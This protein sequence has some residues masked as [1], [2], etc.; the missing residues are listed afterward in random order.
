MSQTSDERFKELAMKL[1]SFEC[2]CEEKA[3]LRRII[4]QE[5]ARREELQTRCLSVGIAREL[6]PLAN[7]LEAT[8]GQISVRELEAFKDALARRRK[9]LRNRSPET[10]AAPQVEAKPHVLSAKELEILVLKVL[11]ERP[12]DGFELAG[13]LR[14]AKVANLDGGEGTV[15]G[16]LARLEASGCLLGRWRPDGGR[17]A[18]TYHVTEK[19]TTSLRGS[20]ALMGNLEEVARSILAVDGAGT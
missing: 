16:L 13:S 15:Y 6:L 10:S 9:E 5:P 3:E 2:S 17:M 12:M 1:V 8:E 11:S 4:E 19:G 18:K 20:R 7:A 14:K